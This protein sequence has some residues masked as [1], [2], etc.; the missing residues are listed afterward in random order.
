MRILLLAAVSALAMSTAALGAEPA[1]PVYGDWGVDLTAG[2]KSV[3]VSWLAPTSN[4]GAPIWV[5]GSAV[6]IRVRS[7]SC[8]RL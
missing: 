3:S 4:G 7:W 5:E 6:S 8:E 2:D 1:K